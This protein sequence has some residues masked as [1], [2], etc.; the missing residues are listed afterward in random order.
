MTSSIDAI[1]FEFVNKPVRLVATRKISRIET[2][3]LIVEEVEAGGD[4]SINLWLAWELMEAG[5]A[6]LADDGIS[7]EEWTQIHYRERFQPIGQLSP[8]PDSFYSRVHLT[9][10]R[11]KKRGSNDPSRLSQLDRM[12]GMFRDIIESRIVKIVRMAS[13]EAV[14]SSRSLQPEEA[15]LYRD[16]QALI[17]SWRKALRRLGE[18]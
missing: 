6:R 2:A 17:S 7:G 10:N 15:A 18:G 13:A 3:G 4:L 11:E 14:S 1:S 5:L 9:F 8:L 16:L 12:Q